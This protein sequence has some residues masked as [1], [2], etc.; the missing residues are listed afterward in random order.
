MKAIHNGE[1]AAQGF[2]FTVVNK[3]KIQNE[4]NS[5]LNKSGSLL[6]QTVVNKAKISRWVGI[7]KMY[8]RNEGHELQNK[9]TICE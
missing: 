9:Y 2:I 1:L 6:Y 7:N 3:A 8:L 4:S 5:Q